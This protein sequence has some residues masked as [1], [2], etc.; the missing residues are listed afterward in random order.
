MTRTSMPSQITLA[1]LASILCIAGGACAFEPDTGGT[2][3]SLRRESALGASGSFA[4]LANAAVTCTN[5]TITGDVGTALATPTGSITQTSCPVTGAVSVG[6]AGSVSAYDD[7]LVAYDAA[8]AQ[9][10]DRVLTGTLDGVVLAPGVYCFD[11][12]ATLTGTLTLD[13]PASGT[14][15]FQI[16]TS[17]VG[18]LTGTDFSIV[19]VGGSPC[20]V[21]WWVAEAVTM[22]DSNFVGTILS[23]AAITLSRGTFE[24]R[25]LAQADVTI[26]DTAVTGCAGGSATGGGGGEGCSRPHRRCNQGL[27]NGSEGCDPGRSNHRHSSN[28]EGGGTPGKPGRHHR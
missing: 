3:A 15:L 25:A 11:A 21:T 2:Q 23:G 8:S 27:G 10:C 26:T 22:T 9:P 24:G 13:G 1:S 7:F 16:G 19:M 5:A 12:A 18:A 17:G 28:D 6:T 20:N 4:V 14:W